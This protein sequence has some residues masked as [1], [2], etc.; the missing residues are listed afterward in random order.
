MSDVLFGLSIA[1]VCGFAAVLII[2]FCVLVIYGVIRL[3]ERQDKE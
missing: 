3:I 1:M 2:A